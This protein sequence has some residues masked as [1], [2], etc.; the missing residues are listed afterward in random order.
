[1]DTNISLRNALCSK[2]ARP[3]D[4]DLINYYVG[5]YRQTSM[6][7]RNALG[8]LWRKRATNVKLNPLLLHGYK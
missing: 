8:A 6:D 4:F 2:R 5:V 3:S 1:M 7:Y